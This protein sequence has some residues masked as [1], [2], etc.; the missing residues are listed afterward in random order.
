MGSTSALTWGLSPARALPIICIFT[1]FLGGTATPTSCRC[2]GLPRWCPRPYA[3][4]PPSCATRSAIDPAQPPFMPTATLHFENAR[5]AHQLLNND[6]QN[7]HALEQIL[8]VKATTRDGWIKLEGPDD[9]LERAK[10]LFQLLESSLKSG[11]P[12]RGRDFSHALNVIQSEGVGAL[13]ELY[14]QRIQ[15]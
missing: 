9:A 10:Q 8:G 7:L 11:H 3:N 6:P 4:W 12:V 1:S 15:T 2:W 5:F 14:A 13:K